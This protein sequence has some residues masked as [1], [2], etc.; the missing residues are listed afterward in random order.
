M[1][2]KNLWKSAL[3]LVVSGLL[4]A[5]GAAPEYADSYT[6]FLPPEDAAAEKVFGEVTSGRGSN[7]A[8]VAYDTAGSALQPAGDLDRMI[9]WN[10]SIYVTV[11]DTES[12]I[13]L[14]Q[15][16][17]HDRGG[18]TV[19]TESWLDND[20][21]HA[22]LTIRVPA[23]GFEEAMREL[24]R[25]AL[26]VDRETANSE[27]VTDQYVDLESRLRHLEAKEEQLLQ[28]LEE[29][30]DTE[31]VL[32]VYG[33]LSQT[34][35]E[36]EQVKGRMTYLQK[37]SAMAT[38]TIELYP[39][40]AEPPVVEEGWKPGRTLRNAARALVGALEAVGNGI[41]WIAIY[42]LPIILLLAL[43]IALA[44]WL[45]RRRKARRSTG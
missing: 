26:E 9:I 38:I 24:R 43:P 10:A 4:G 13:E 28:F 7:P 39:E 33:H 14:V 8:A 35:A 19:S 18:Y 22:R 5:C 34:Q 17:A 6:D 36:I 11:E 37:L 15:D 21:L 23:E 29:A 12:A 44:F 25:L 27:D 2:I 16:L 30:E 31:A 1:K 20:Q 40:E 3:L 41:I 45:L 42:V 32:A